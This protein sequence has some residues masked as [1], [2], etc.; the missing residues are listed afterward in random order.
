MTTLSERILGLKEVDRL[1][2]ETGSIVKDSWAHRQIIEAAAALAS[3]NNTPP[4][5]DV[6][7]LQRL[8]D[9]WPELDENHPQKDNWFFVSGMIVGWFDK[10]KITI[11]QLL[12]AA[13]TN[14]KKGG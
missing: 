7:A 2:I 6:G 14:E 11:R 10:N 8:R 12:D 1:L 3:D 4:V 9:E 5:Q 13:L